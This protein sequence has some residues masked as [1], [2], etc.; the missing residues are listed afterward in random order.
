MAAQAGSKM[1]PATSVV[2]PFH[3]GQLHAIARQF[4]VDEDKLIDFSAS[5][6]PYPPP[7]RVLERLR[8]CAADEAFLSAYPDLEYGDLKAAISAYASISIDAIAVGNGMMPLLDASLLALSIQR[9]LVV[10]PCFAGYSRSLATARVETVAFAL[11]PEEGFSL[12]SDRLYSALEKHG[13]DALLLA[14]PHSPSGV[15]TP[16]AVLI[17][18]CQR[19]ASAGVTV[20]LDEAFID[21]EPE[22]S[23]CSFAAHQNN[24]IVFRSLT[25]FLA[26]PAMR[27]AYA[28]AG[29]G[30][31][32]AISKA[33]P[34]WPIGSLASVAAVELLGCAGHHR[35][36]RESNAA[37][38][39]ALSRSMREL[40]I[41][42]FP[43]QA[44]Y[45]LARMPEEGV[46]LSI[47]QSLIVDHGMVLRCCQN[48]PGLDASYLR[49]SVR[50]RKDNDALV[51]ALRAVLQHV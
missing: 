18:L 14:N 29:S 49:L 25:K 47:W 3:G 38:R 8:L 30:L 31:A 11:R 33:M 9:C 12:S 42:V 10:Q 48:F 28:A 24:L 35:L 17:E 1:K 5:I 4:N 41:A 39:E 51:K 43:S 2:L 45:L 50:T 19:A 7:E 46:G 44:N 36:V 26:I 34:E 32:R 6:S 21:F 16:P 40:G 27:V 15:L 37:L 23:L 13:C 20:L 22:S